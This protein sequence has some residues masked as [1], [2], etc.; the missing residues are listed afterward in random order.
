MT[1]HI[2]F[3]AMERVK[4]NLRMSG[5]MTTLEGYDTKDKNQLLHFENKP[6]QARKAETY[7][8]AYALPKLNK[9]LRQVERGRSF[10]CLF[11]KPP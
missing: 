6:N 11:P 2:R 10:L 7:N 4:L 5:Q 1:S 3:E 9:T 8:P